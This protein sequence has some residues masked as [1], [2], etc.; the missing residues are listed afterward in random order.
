MYL[1]I[2]KY[3]LIHVYQLFRAYKITTLHVNKYFVSNTHISLT[4]PKSYLAILHQQY[5]IYNEFIEI[6]Q[7]FMTFKF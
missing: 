6:F 3:R 4:I 1:Y 7:Y 5:I 2:F